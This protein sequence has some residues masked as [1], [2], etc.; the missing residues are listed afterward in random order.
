LKGWRF[1]DATDVIKN[2]TEDLKK[3]SQNVFQKCFQ[4][5]YSHWQKFTVA[6]KDHF[7]GN[8]A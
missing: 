8:T 6:Q 3:L 2:V 7:E 5:L 1:S 4:H